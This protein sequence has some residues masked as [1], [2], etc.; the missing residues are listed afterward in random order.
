[1]DFAYHRAVAPML[2]VFVA[3]ASVELVVVHLLASLLL[4]WRVAMVLSGLSLATVIWIVLLIR[5]FPRLPVRVAEGRV[6]MRIGTLRSAEFAVAD[7]ARVRRHWDG[8]ELKRPGVLNLA[9]IA[10]PNV[11]IDLRAPIPGRKPIH[12]VGH[13]LDSP[14]AFVAALGEVAA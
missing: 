5:S 4:D 11:L 6:L 13:R 10:Y 7:I 1:M 2:W 9:L 14:D 3:I 8:A 12:A